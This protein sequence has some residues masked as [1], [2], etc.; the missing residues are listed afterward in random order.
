MSSTKSY[1]DLQDAFSYN[2]YAELDNMA[3]NFTYY[4]TQGK[5]K[6]SN[7]YHN[8]NND[9]DN[10]GSFDTASKLTNN[11]SLY[12]KTIDSNYSFLNTLHKH[13]YSKNIS[14]D[15]EKDRIVNNKHKKNLK[16]K[17]YEYA[18][19]ID[20]EKINKID[21][22]YN[23]LKQNQ[24]SNLNDVETENKKVKKELKKNVAHETNL[25]NISDVKDV[26]IILLIGIAVIIILDILLRR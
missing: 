9:N 16:K 19:R 10:D 3:R 6:K 11:E 24:A 23:Y 14:D 8:D 20:E 2:D 15:F 22:I 7:I 13:G 18:S 12:D 17:E 5:L 1:S 4:D 26:I 25:L 21:F